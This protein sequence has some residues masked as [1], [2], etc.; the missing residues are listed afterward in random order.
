M[1]PA[2]MATVPHNPTVAA[3]APKPGGQEVFTTSTQGRRARQCF[4]PTPRSH[5]TFQRC[6]N[7]VLGPGW[8]SSA[9]E[10]AGAASLGMK[11]SAHQMTF[12]C[13]EAVCGVQ[14]KR[15]SPSE[16]SEGAIL[17]T[18]APITSAF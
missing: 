5:L 9:W 16:C 4:T 15:L 3:P 6:R 2:Q 11:N 17:R 8:S 1:T 13:F 18:T 10:S 14:I 12:L 7:S